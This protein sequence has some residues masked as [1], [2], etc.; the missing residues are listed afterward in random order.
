MTPPGSPQVTKKWHSTELVSPL[1]RSPSAQETTALRLLPT[2]PLPQH[3]HTHSTS[4]GVVKRNEPH[5]IEPSTSNAITRELGKRC[6][7]GGFKV[8][9]S[10][11]MPNQ[12]PQP[13]P[14]E[15][16]HSEDG[17]HFS[18][19]ASQE[20]YESVVDSDWGRE[21]ED[22]T[23]P[24]GERIRNIEKTLGTAQHPVRNMNASTVCYVCVYSFKV[25][26]CEATWRFLY[27]HL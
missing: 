22:A 11:T 19:S 25:H 18:D 7:L 1:L 5:L 2:P 9:D 24:I 14:R 10:T 3:H 17:Q 13:C 16:F 6:P 4:P 23:R 8:A 26:N 12:R 21:S 15:R 20:S 27:T